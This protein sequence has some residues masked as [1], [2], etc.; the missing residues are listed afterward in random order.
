M[1]NLIYNGKTLLLGGQGRLSYTPP[2][3]PAPLLFNTWTNTAWD[4]FETSGINITS[5]I[6]LT[7]SYGRARTEYLTFVAGDHIQGQYFLTMNSGS[8]PS[9]QLISE[10]LAGTQVATYSMI[11]G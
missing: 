3:P 9:I 1:P 5:A 7:G 4:T 11:D 2:A 6:E 10:A 8:K